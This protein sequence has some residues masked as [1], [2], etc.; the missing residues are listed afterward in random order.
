AD[1]SIPNLEAGS[2]S[3]RRSYLG[4]YPSTI[5]T[6]PSEPGNLTSA[7]TLFVWHAT[8]HPA[9]GRRF[10][11]G[12]VSIGATPSTNHQTTK[13]IQHAFTITGSARG[14]QRNTCVWTIEENDSTE[15]GVPS[16]LQL[17]VLVQHAGPVMVEV[18]ISGWTAGGFFPSHRL[19]PKTGAEGRR[20]V[21]RPERYKG[22]LD[23]Y[24]LDDD[25]GNSA[26]N[27][28]DKWTGRVDGAMLQF[29]QDVV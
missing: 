5:Q 12:P 26:V 7:T 10:S 3:P 8:F 28:L 19:R 1:T 24:N 23:E 9:V 20:K 14:P 15:R 13:E 18:D 27:M 6:T 25:K 4:I 22:Q 21:F 2:G 17:A 29:D 16:E 11:M